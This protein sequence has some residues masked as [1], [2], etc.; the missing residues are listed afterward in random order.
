MVDRVVQCY[1]DEQTFTNGYPAKK[2]SIIK[3]I[4]QLN[5]SEILV[6]IKY[7]VGQLS[8]PHLIF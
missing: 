1:Y 2:N 8:G 7:R 5:C 4:E 3:A 6:C